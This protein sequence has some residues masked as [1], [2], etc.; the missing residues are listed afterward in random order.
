[1]T[2]FAHA[3]S[4]WKVTRIIDG[5]TFEVSSNFGDRETVRPIGIDTPERGEPCFKEAGAQLSAL[6]VNKNV[7]L[8]ASASSDTRDGYGRL[9]RYVEID[10]RDIGL[11]LITDGWAVAAY[12]S[13]STE[14]SP[15]PKH[16]REDLYR[17]EDQKQ[18]AQICQ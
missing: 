8:V 10:G 3:G 7:D 4:T 12:D 6:I 17:A 9:L 13:Q 1:V 18:P 16:D 11:Q 5:D 14:K 15:Y 2:S